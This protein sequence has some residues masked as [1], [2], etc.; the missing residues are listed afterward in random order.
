MSKFQ[1][2]LGYLFISIMVDVMWQERNNY[3]NGRPK[4][5][6]QLLGI[7]KLF[8]CERALSRREFHETNLESLFYINVVVT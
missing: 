7:I 5:V 8:T 2:Y 1:E 6:S 4:S 3:H